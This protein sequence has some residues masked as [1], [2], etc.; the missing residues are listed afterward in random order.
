MRNRGTRTPRP[1]VA[2]S[3]PRIAPRKAAPGSGPTR[4]PSAKRHPASHE[5]NGPPP[6]RHGAPLIRQVQKYVDRARSEFGLDNYSIVVHPDYARGNEGTAEAE[7]FVQYTEA[8]LHL[9]YRFFER[10][11]AT[12][13]RIIAHELAHIFSEPLCEIVRSWEVP[14]AGTGPWNVAIEYMTEHLERPLARILP[15]PNFSDD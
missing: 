15:L 4:A 7:I 3:H 13:R 11:R 1:A 10:P 5:D 12:Q 14:V 8:H 6:G 2:V 9:G